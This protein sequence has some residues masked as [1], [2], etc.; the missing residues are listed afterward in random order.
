MKTG[1]YT[2]CA[3]CTALFLVVP[4][5]ASP[6]VAE[7]AVIIPDSFSFN[8]DLKQGVTV[9]P[10][11]QYLQAILNASPSTVVAATGSGSN[12]ELTSTFGTKTKDAVMRFQNFYAASILMP[13][14][15]SSATGIVGPLTR[16]KL[17]LILLTARNAKAK[18]VTTGTGTAASTG[19]IV[20][21]SAGASAATG[22]APTITSVSP[23][24]SKFLTQVIVLTGTN[25]TSNNTV[26]TNLGNIEGVYSV[27]GKNLIF[28]VGT[29]PYYQ[30]ALQ[31]YKG[32]QINLVIGVSTAFGTSLEQAIHIISLPAS[33]SL[34]DASPVTTSDILQSIKDLQQFAASTTESMILQAQL[35]SLM[36]SSTASSTATSTVR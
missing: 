3:L 2:L 23:I 9:S 21:T 35:M 28:T 13:A 16:A 33:G 31:A 19:S 15:L 30:K 17:N 24:S 8:L 27:D 10:D 6:N 25:F 12:F 29:L 4:I 22:S 18:A 14:G 5:A 7:A 1:I 36:A 34:A 26:K 11:V 20:T 32:K